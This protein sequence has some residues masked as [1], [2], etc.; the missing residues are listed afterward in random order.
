M[1]GPTMSDVQQQGRLESSPMAM[2][3]FR[4]PD[5]ESSQ[6]FFRYFASCSKMMTECNAELLR[7]WNG[8][9]KY[10]GE[11]L[12]AITQCAE[13][14]KAI[15]MEQ[16]WFRRTVEDYATETKCLIELNSQMVENVWG[17]AQKTDS[18][19]P[20]AKDVPKRTA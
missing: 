7:F 16:A 15:E 14:P 19:A 1:K 4:W 20:V 8:R 17:S 13:W 12:R 6:P 18:R 3:F 2:G 11:T 10:D 5:A 9:M